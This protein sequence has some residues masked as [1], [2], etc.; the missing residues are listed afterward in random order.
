VSFPHFG[1]LALHDD[2]GRLPDLVAVMPNDSHG[3]M[4]W[5]PDHYVGNEYFL[6]VAANES[7]ATAAALL[8]AY[9]EALA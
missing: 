8:A 7:P 6:P 5:S 3:A 2:A 4:W 1:C 9:A